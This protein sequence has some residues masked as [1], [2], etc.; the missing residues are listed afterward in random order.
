MCSSG[1]HPCLLKHKIKIIKY[2]QKDAC[3]DVRAVFRELLVS[4]VTVDSQ[5]KPRFR[6][7]KE[8]FQPVI[9]LRLCYSYVCSGVWKCPQR[10]HCYWRVLTRIMDIAALAN[11]TNGGHL[12]AQKS[13][14]NAFKEA[15]FAELTHEGSLNGG[16]QTGTMGWKGP[17]TNTCSEIPAEL[18]NV[19][20]SQVAK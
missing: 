6:W 10:T 1:T 7:N 4:M 13:N 16:V 8:M 15:P 12:S 3:R 19:F 11:I 2:R 17:V 5:A 9:D 18:L 14:G 20:F